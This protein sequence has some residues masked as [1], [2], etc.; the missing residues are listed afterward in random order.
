MSALRLTLAEPAAQ[1]LAGREDVDALERALYLADRRVALADRMLEELGAAARRR[2]SARAGEAPVDDDIARGLAALRAAR[3][4]AIAELD[5]V[6]DAVLQL[7]I[8]VGLRTLAGGRLP[9]QERLQD[10]QARV[11]ALAELSSLELACAS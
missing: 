9:V 11:A 8:Q 10:L 6:L 1:G 3:D 7:R 2:P 4:H 5:A